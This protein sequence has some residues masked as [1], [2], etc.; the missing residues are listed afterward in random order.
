MMSMEAQ[1][2]E[3]DTRD[4]LLATATEFVQSRGYNAFSYRDLA[5]RVG[6][7]TASIHYHF[8]TKAD[9]GREMMIRHRRENR[10][11]FERVD[12]AGGSAL[13]RLQ[14]YC[15]GFRKA[16][17]QGSRICLG[18]MM[19]TDS[20]SLPAEVLEEVRG[21]YEDHENWLARTIRQGQRDGEVKSTGSPDGVARMLFDALEGAMLATRAF[22]TPRRLVVAIDWHL[23]QITPERS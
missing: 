20:E 18:G 7:R 12:Q 5:E 2:V 11:F 6:I 17:G 15:D 4:K 3:I 22:R 8:P 14:R 13:D 23:S 10:D 9:L 1:A 19:A 21:C 16:Y